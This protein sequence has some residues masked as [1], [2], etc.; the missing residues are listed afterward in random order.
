MIIRKGKQIS[1]TLSGVVDCTSRLS[2]TPDVTL[3]LSPP[4]SIGIPS[5]H[6]CIRLSRWAKSPGTVSFVPPDGPFTLLDYETLDVNNIDIPIRIEAKLDETAEFEIR[7]TPGGKKLEDLT[8]TIPL[9]PTITGATNTRP[10]RGDF[11]TTSKLL[12]WTIPN[13]KPSAGMLGAGR[14]GYV[15]KGQFTGDDD[16]ILPSDVVVR[17]TCQGWLASGVTVGGLRVIGTGVADGVGKGRGGIYKGV[18][19]ITNIEVIVRL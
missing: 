16:M 19:G 9:N 17:F 6:P 10:S 12:T 3:T 18:K 5:F 8:I 1:T 11:V 15:L 13:D 2:L 14:P 4:G 7:L